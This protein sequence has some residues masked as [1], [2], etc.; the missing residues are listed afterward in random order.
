MVSLR[1][2]RALHT[3][4]TSRE[5]TLS[6]PLKLTP[7]TPCILVSKL[8]SFQRHSEDDASAKDSNGLDMSGRARSVVVNK[9]KKSS[10]VWTGR[11]S[12]LAQM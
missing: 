10:V 8:V 7:Q 6:I 12:A 1:L 4:R 5:A 9:K 3:H 11:A 2:R